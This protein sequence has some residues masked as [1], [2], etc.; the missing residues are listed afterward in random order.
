[1]K[2]IKTGKLIKPFV[3]IAVGAVC[4]VSAVVL[5]YPRGK[6]FLRLDMPEKDKKPGI[7]EIDEIMLGELIEKALSK[8]LPLK[9]LKT[10][11]SSEKTITL[12]AEAET[13]NLTRLLE[14]SNLR[15]PAGTRLILDLL[16]KKVT[17]ELKLG[18]GLA[19]KDKSIKLTPVELKI[20][21]FS[22][23]GR[24][25]PEKLKTLLNQ[26]INEFIKLNNIRIT[27]IEITD[28]KIILL[29]A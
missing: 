19:D 22:I 25:I 8:T 6:R 17:S 9:G 28:G 16:P 24:M 1:M 27:D 15:V 18:I 13:E 5:L 23:K 26:S 4:V 3:F 2:I 11:I 20:N 14:Q 12:S 21:E 7:T 29:R 10:V